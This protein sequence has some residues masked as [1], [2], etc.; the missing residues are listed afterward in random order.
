MRSFAAWFLFQAALTVAAAV[1]ALAQNSS[2]QQPPSQ[3]AGTA[4]IE[5]TVRDASGQPVA[6]AFVVLVPKEAEGV[7]AKTVA[8]KASADGRF[9]LSAI[10]AGAFIL[11]AKKAGSREGELYDSATYSLELLPGEKKHVDLVLVATSPA[12]GGKGNVAQGGS[13]AAAMEF[14]DQPNFTVAGMTDWSNFGLHGSDAAAKTSEALTKETLALKSNSAPANPA[15]TK[16]TS[17]A[18]GSGAGDR[19]VAGNVSGAGSDVAAAHRLAGDRVEALHDPVAAVHE[20]ETAARLDPSE[21]NYF[22]WG[23]E[24]L[25]HRATQPAAEV[26]A[27]G[28]GAHPESA[29]LLVGLGAALYADG[30]YDDA[31]R[32]LCAA[33]DLNPAATAP[34]LF[35]GKMEETATAPIACGEEKLA[36]FVRE[37]PANAL[38]NYYYALSLT[39]RE[40]VSEDSVAF[41][42]IETLLEKS[43]SLDPS[44]GEAYVQLGILYSAKEDFARAEEALRK[45]IAAKPELGLAHY[46][47]GQA[48]KHTGDD[49]KAQEEFAIY[50]QCEKTEADARAR[51]QRELR[52]FLVILKE[53]PAAAPPK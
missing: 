19:A 42:Q 35:L 14:A 40:R 53:E 47:L 11:K 49:A 6:G 9:R 30:R 45:G 39:K 1:P 50:A 12:A 32:K 37:Q 5:G 36:R 3:A 46:R 48:Y 2:T 27:A 31:A 23:S 22:A 25:L 29:R 38:A 41:R 15:D 33:S 10:R 26:F 13:S 8:T 18:N 16:N 34:Y 44:L 20:Y 51:E 24:L 4:S 52:Q 17:G 21:E 28:S 43:V 7:N